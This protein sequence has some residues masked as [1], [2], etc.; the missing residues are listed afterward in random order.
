MGKLFVNITAEHDVNGVIKPILLNWENG[1]VFTVDKILDVRQAAS[2]KS[3][4][5]GMRYTCH[6]AG[7]QVY[8]FC[9]EGRWFIEK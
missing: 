1:R 5:Q 2:L 6:I 7:K 4:G 3:G 9:D 8:L